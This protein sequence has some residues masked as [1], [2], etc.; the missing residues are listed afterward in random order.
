MIYLIGGPPRCGKTTLAKAMSKQY[1][2]SWVSTDMLA[3]VGAAYTP[4]QEWVK[5]HPYS[6]L[7]RK[8]SARGLRSND[9]FYEA[10]PTAKIVSVLKC[11]AKA[12]FLAV[13]MM[14]ACEIADGNNYIIEGYHIEPA[15]AKKLIK[16][17][18]AKKVKA[19][20]LTKHDAKKFAIDVHKSTTPNDW[21]IVLTKKKETF[22]KVGEMVAAYSKIL[23]SEAKK[24]GFKAVAMDVDLEKKLKMA[25]ENLRNN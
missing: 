23:E 8:F 16:K 24:Y 14:V 15:F 3:T 7:R 6:V 4:K 25:M 12:A 11:E 20:F 5:T 10:L 1:G 19:I 18:G 2:I 13:E 17:Y 9:D 22:L 21:L